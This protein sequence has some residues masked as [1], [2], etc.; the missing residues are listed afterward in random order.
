MKYVYV[1]I[2]V[3]EKKAV[4]DILKNKQKYE[5]KEVKDVEVFRI[6]KGNGITKKFDFNTEL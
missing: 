3:A 5:Q 6:Q 1:G 2:Y 4:K